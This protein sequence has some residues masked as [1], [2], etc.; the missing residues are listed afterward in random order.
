MLATDSITC[1]MLVEISK[2]QKEGRFH[3]IFKDDFLIR[4]VDLGIPI[5]NS[6]VNMWKFTNE[7]II[8]KLEELREEKE[9]LK[10]SNTELMEYIRYAL[11]STSSS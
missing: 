2:P 7:K 6:M 1:H 4:M 5:H 10:A 8:Y 3:E 11:R 9:V